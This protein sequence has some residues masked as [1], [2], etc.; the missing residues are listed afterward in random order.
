MTE[1]RPF[2]FVAMLQ[3]V[4][5][6]QGGDH[7]G[8]RRRVYD[9]V[10]ATGEEVTD[11][12]TPAGRMGWQLMLPE[13]G[14]T[15]RMGRLTSGSAPVVD[16][17]QTGSAGAVLGTVV[18]AE[19]NDHG[20]VGRIRLISDDKLPPAIRAGL[21]D[22]VIQ[23]LSV[24][25]IPHEMRMR[26]QKNPPAQIA[27]IMDWEP[28]ELSLVAAGRDSGAHMR[29]SIMQMFQG[30]MLAPAD[31]AVGGEAAPNP[32]AILATERGRIAGIASICQ[33][34]GL[35]PAPHYASGATVEAV[36]A[37]LAAR[38]TLHG[39]EGL[40][41][42]PAEDAAPVDVAATIRQAQTDAVEIME[43]CASPL[44]RNPQTG[45]QPAPGTFIAQ[46]M[47][48]ADVRARLWIDAD[49]IARQGGEGQP[50]LRQAGQ[51]HDQTAQSRL[52]RSISNAL[53]ERGDPR[54]IIAAH[55]K[56]K[57]GVLTT[58]HSGISLKEGR[59]A[60][61]DGVGLD[62]SCGGRPDVRGAAAR[63]CD[64]AARCPRAAVVPRRRHPP[65]GPA[66]G[67]GDPRRAGDRAGCR[68]R[69]GRPARRA[70]RR[71][72]ERRRRERHA[73]DAQR[74]LQR[75]RGDVHLRG[76]DGHD[77]EPGLP[78]GA[79]RH[80]GGDAQPVGAHRD[81]GLPQGT[82]AEPREGDDAGQ[83]ARH[84]HRGR[85]D[86]DRERRPRRPDADHAEQRH[87]DSSH[88]GRRLLRFDQHEQRAGSEHHRDGRGGQRLQCHLRQHC[89]R[90]ERNRA[91]LG[92][93]QHRS[94]GARKAEGALAGRQGVRWVQVRHAVVQPGTAR[95]GEG[96][97]R[98]REGPGDRQPERDAGRVQAHH[99]VAASRRHDPPLPFQHGLDG[100][101]PV[102]PVLPEL[103]RLDHAV[104]RDGPS[105]FTTRGGVWI[106]AIDFGVQPITNRGAH[107]NPGA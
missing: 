106:V 88:P 90:C 19:V 14:G 35:D 62:A 60:A 28:V 36:R 54:R 22:G 82:R 16:S 44:A 6:E 57:D 2:S 25:A 3:A 65:G 43:I 81:R 24:Q 99:R 63:R 27:E 94:G 107:F 31:T 53:V 1:R 77:H 37:A 84:G 69:D 91:D 7:N 56:P 49:G 41:I 42:E 55:E 48:P 61:A 20:L 102:D 30:P 75:R 45:E 100:R 47:S 9:V 13:Q 66:R 93:P 50:P 46:G 21:E 39:N 85:P 74:G 101:R 58:D 67:R 23:N 103:L 95:E 4:A 76:V 80:D 87:R 59:P 40:R 86:H 98:R 29:E 96:H 18:S 32:E 10:M 79:A 83:R 92:E 68:R 17:H 51:S 72:S 34:A 33:A 5:P 11:V 38:P 64:H 8:G 78:P 52:V 70:G 15:V 12:T 105:P 104:S 73:P 97:P 89:R 26:K 71:R